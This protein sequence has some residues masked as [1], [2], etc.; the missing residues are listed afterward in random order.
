MPKKT[1]KE[2]FLKAKLENKGADYLLILILVIYN[3]LYRLE[4]EW[5]FWLPSLRIE[6]IENYIYKF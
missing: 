2:G 3:L 4:R 6:K 5:R 1:Y